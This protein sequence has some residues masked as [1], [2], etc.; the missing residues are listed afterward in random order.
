MRPMHQLIS[1]RITQ[2]R[3]LDSSCQEILSVTQNVL[4]AFRQ[5]ATLKMGG[6]FCLITLIDG[7]GHELKEMSSIVVR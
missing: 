2:V 7:T 6:W 4:T 5:T 1:S 3:Q